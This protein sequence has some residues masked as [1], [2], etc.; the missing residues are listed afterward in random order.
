VYPISRIQYTAIFSQRERK[1]GI[2][3]PE[4]NV[5]YVHTLH[6]IFLPGQTAMEK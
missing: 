6:A 1:A 4:G 3:L 5:P 2:I